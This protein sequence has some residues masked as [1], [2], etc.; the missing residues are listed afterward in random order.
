[1]T[2]IRAANSSTSRGVG[3]AKCLPDRL[4]VAEDVLWLMK[5]P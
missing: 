3:S 4:V 1:M 5:S 2:I